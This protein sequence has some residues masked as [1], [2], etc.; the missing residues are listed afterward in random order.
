MRKIFT[1]LAVMLMAVSVKVY[2]AGGTASDAYLDIANYAT[3]NNASATV[4]GMSSIYKYTEYT[5][6]QCAWLTV[7]TY[8]AQQVDANQNWYNFE[9]T[10][11]T[12]TGTWTASDIFMGSSSYFTGTAYYSNWNEAYQNFYV[13]NCSQVKQLAYNIQSSY[14]TGN[15]YPMKMYIYECTLNAN[16]TLTA[17]TSTVD[18]KESTT[19]NQDEVVSSIDLDPTKIYLVKIYNDYSRFYEIG[20]KTPLVP[21]VDIN[22]P[23]ATEATEI[24]T[25]CFTANWNPCGEVTSYTLRVMPSNEPDPFMVLSVRF[26][27]FTAEGTTDLGQSLNDY[28]DNAEWY[29]SDVYSAEGGIRLGTNNNVGYLITPNLS[30]GTT[31][32]KLSV[33]LK[34]KTYGTD[35]NCGLSVTYGSDSGETIIVD[36]TEA[37]YIIVVDCN[38]PHGQMIIQNSRSYE[39]RII[40]TDLEIYAGDIT[41]EDEFSK[42]RANETNVDDQLIVTGITETSYKVTG[43]EPGTKY[44]YDVKAVYGNQESD[45]SNQ[46]KVITLEDP[47]TTLQYILEEGV[48][49]NEYTI[50]NNL[51]VVDIADNANYAF[52]TDGKNNWIRVNATNNTYFNVFV[53][54]QFIEGG[55]ITGTLSGVDTNPLLT[56]K[57][58][59]TA[60]NN[61]IIFEIEELNLA[62]G[63][64]AP[65]VNQVVDIVGWWNDDALHAFAPSTGDQGQSLALDWTWGATSNTLENSKQYKVRCAMLIDNDNNYIGYALRLPEEALAEDITTVV[66]G[67]VN[68][69]GEVTSADITALY[70]FLLTGDDSDIVNGDQ[71]GDGDITTHDVT[72][73]YEILL[74]AKK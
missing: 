43:L 34:A 69:D 7:C 68:G 27:K 18:Y 64:I 40:I 38:A 73:V 45:W 47:E 29:G 12:S 74:G 36:N 63:E 6:Q 44:Y 28:M 35:V 61:D 66:A 37:E 59:P 52:L 57:A 49:G 9:G 14:N 70:T 55:T 17:S 62:D 48:D 72:V 11:K 4:S 51:A 25:D 16:G 15:V 39:G 53:N 50:T 8:G 23:V 58:K 42:T 41:I 54:N 32:D 33:K 2:A 5:D 46:I 60:T 13:T 20:F 56:V 71:D 3:I 24:G 30:F 10:A 1:L 22:K 19:T 65:K 21:A 31:F 67:D 26:T